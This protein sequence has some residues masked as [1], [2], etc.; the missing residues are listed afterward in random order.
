MTMA[1]ATANGDPSINSQQNY[2][3]VYVYSSAAPSE[4]VTIMAS[5]LFQRASLFCANKLAPAVFKN[6][7]ARVVGGSLG[8]DASSTTRFAFANHQ[9]QQQQVR[10]KV[11]KAKL[12]R[13]I[14]HKR[15]AAWA[16]KGKEIPK[17]PGYMPRD[18]LVENVIPREVVEER[19]REHDAL[20]KRELE[21]RRAKLLNVTPLRYQMTGLKMSDRVRKLFDLNN[22][23]QSEVVQYQ[24]QSGMRLFEVRE[25]D[26]GS[27]AVQGKK[28]TVLI[29]FI[30][31]FICCSS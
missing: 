19:I 21:E 5:T 26:T 11:T 9:N 2:C 31:Q 23:N 25:G 22:G 4:A 8:G 18:T 28:Y 7:A 13:R 10:F 16:E 24:K 17:P 14:R 3:V 20:V 12:K 29:L 30:C 6:T 1:V 15:R 27:S